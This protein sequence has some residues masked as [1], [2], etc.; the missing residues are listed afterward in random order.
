M[1]VIKKSGL[2]QGYDINKV[3]IALQ[4]TAKSINEEFKEADWKEIKPR[5]LA[6]LESVIEGREEIFFWEIDDAVIDSLLRSRFK[7]IAREYIQSRTRTR[8]DR[9]N[10]LGIN[11]V[12][13]S[14]IK[15]RYLRKDSDGKPLET[16]KE[17]MC[18]VATEIARVEKDKKLRLEYTEKFTN[19]LCSL[20]FLPNSPALVSAGAKHKGTY[21]ACYAYGIEDSLEDIMAVVYKTAKT[22]Q[23]GGGVGVSIAKLRE[24]GAKIETTNGHSSGS[25][26]FLK[27]FDTMCT[28]I[29]TGGFRRGALMCLNEYDHPDIEWFI[30]C[31][32]DTKVL[33]NMN[34]SVLTNDKFFESIKKNEDVDLISRK[35]KQPIAKI[36]ANL[37][38]DRMN[39][40]NPTPHLGDI[41]LTNPCS[42]SN[43]RNNEAC[44]LGS[45]NLVNHLNEDKS[46]MN[47]DKLALT[48]KLAV[49]FLDNML[50]ATPYPAPEVEKETLST[51]KIGLGVM[52][53]ADVLI[54]L[55]VKYSSKDAIVWANKIMSFVNDVAIEESI[56]LGK[57]KGIYPE[58]KPKYQQRRNAI[59][60]VQAP[61]GTLALIAG[62]S[63]GIEPNFYKSYTRPIVGIGDVTITHPLRESPF[64]EIATDVPPEQHLAILAE[65][66]KN[67]ENSVSK[68]LN[69]PET[70]TV[71]E[72]KD[73]IVKAHD[74]N[75]KGITILRERSN[76]EPLIKVN[77]E[78]CK[79]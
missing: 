31:K 42:E 2:R 78:E 25:V 1:D 16:V 7:E 74:M 30:R 38:Y 27:L 68:T 76:R 72:I 61:T 23:L 3:K 29:K 13:F 19:L 36:N 65:F 20:D 60:T 67:I 9:L 6:R 58:C 39:K 28:V 66:Q 57:E 49:R 11:P 48:T 55:K 46:D 51:R 24:Q 32:K 41:R 73:L 47:W 4:K 18:R 69:V 5:I 34:I 37:F 64:F 21:L 44:C 10:D 54:Y 8:Q 53:F 71:Q 33:N 17:M 43:L 35:T 63:S 12:A 75:V 52:G 40:D 50:D 79:I 59:V 77:C 14:V 26:E 62:V 56:D 22:F 45:I 15:E 70:I